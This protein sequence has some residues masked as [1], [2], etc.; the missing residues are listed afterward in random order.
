MSIT[1]VNKT[2][3][4]N[5]TN[6]LSGSFAI[7]ATTPGNLLVISE[8]RL[9]G[10]S[11]GQQT[12]YTGGG[13]SAQLYE[14]IA[15]GFISWNSTL[16]NYIGAIYAYTPAGSTS[17]ITFVNNAGLTGGP[18]SCVVY[19]LAGAVIPALMTASHF[20]A[21]SA[22]SVVGSDLTN[23]NGVQSTFYLELGITG[24]GKFTSTSGQM[25]SLS[26][27]SWN[28]DT[29][30]GIQGGAG[31]GYTFSLNAY[32][33][34][35]IITASSISGPTFSY[36]PNDSSGV[37]SA[38]FG[39]SASS[40][41]L[42]ATPN[43]AVLV[44][45]Q[46]GLITVGVIP[47][48]GFNAPVTLS[49][50][51]LPSG[52]TDGFS[53]NPTN[54]ANNISVLTLH[55]SVTAAVGQ[56]T[57]SVNGVAGALNS[58]TP[59]T[60]TIVSSS[61]PP[62][63]ASYFRYDA[64]MSNPVGPVITGAQVFVC[65]QPMQAAPLTLALGIPSPLATTY[66]DP[67]G[68][69]V[70]TQPA[71]TDGFG[72]TDFYVAAGIYTVLLYW[73]GALHLILPD[74]VIGASGVGS[75]AFATEGFLNTSQSVENLIAGL[76]IT[77]TADSFGGTTI[78][79]TLPLLTDSVANSDQTVYNL[80]SGANILLSGG[81]TISTTIGRLQVGRTVYSVTAADIVRG[82]CI[83]PVLW[84]SAFADTSYTL[85]YSVQ[86]P[87]LSNLSCFEVSAQSVSA[88]GVS[89]VIGGITSTIVVGTQITIHA[90]GIHD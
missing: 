86:S 46:T 14:Q 37:A 8:I 34:F 59:Y 83:I 26:P 21:N 42:V 2:V 81:T 35:Q 16:Y 82:Y 49:E 87:N 73:N 41:S 5:P 44:Q 51:G 24:G 57:V 45:G 53:P 60:L 75:I 32:S 71:I 79:S 48:G 77:V 3:F 43:N 4:N 66:S 19:E 47:N 50:T 61:V 65:N 10:T 64:W 23:P 68:N 30:L 78:A 20:S 88:A 33:A 15:L 85:K 39:P 36:S 55:A 38:V 70:L 7:P 62:P 84:A 13:G 17:L 67:D 72:H 76:N 12:G 28:K 69:L 1:L 22:S 56:V 74:Q 29:I 90:L 6:L 40:F 27:G 52:V 80:I 89:V 25:T 58:S 63:P 54:P 11:G 18:C 9:G 31:A